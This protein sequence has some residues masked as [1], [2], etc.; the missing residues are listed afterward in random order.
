[1]ESFGQAARRPVQ[2]HDVSALNI[3]CAECGASIQELPFEPAPDRPVYC[4]DCNRNRRKN[5]S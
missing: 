4:Q 5:F 1:M 2:M 3:K